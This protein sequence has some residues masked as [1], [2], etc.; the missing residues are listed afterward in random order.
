MPEYLWFEEIPSAA[1]KYEKERIEEI[2]DKFV[3]RDEDTVI[4]NYLKSGKDFQ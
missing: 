3:I 2:P 1:L 4:L